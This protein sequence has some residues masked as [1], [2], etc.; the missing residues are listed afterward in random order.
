MLRILRRFVLPVIL[1]IAIGLRFWRIDT[2]PPGFHFDESFEGLEAWRILTDPG[3][4]PIFLTGNF[5]VAPFNAYANTL[6]FGLFQWWGSAVGPT[7]MRVT[8]ACFGVLGVFAMVGVAAEVRKLD[9]AK[10]PLSSTFPLFA[11]AALAVMRWHIH[12]SRMGI[13]PILVPLTWTVATWLLLRGWRTG[14]WISF[15][16]CGVALAAG[17]YTYQGAWVIPFIM[18]LSVLYLVFSDNWRLE[19]GDW[20][21]GA[22]RTISGTANLQS[23][24]SNLPT[25]RRTGLFLAATVALLL[26]APLAWFF[27]QNWALVFLRP[28]Q[29]AIVGATGSPADTSVW[30]NLWATAKMFGPLGNPGDLDPRRNLPGAPALNLWLAIPF[31][32]GVG[33]A[34]WRIRRPVYA[35]ILTGLV[36]LVVLGVF[37]EYA[38]HFHRILG[39]AA[40]VALLCAVGLDWLWQWQPVRRF[41][42]H[43]VSVLLLILGGATSAHEYFVR[44]AALPELFYAFDD[45]IWQVGQTVAALPGDQP[46]YLTPRAADHPTLAFAW[47][48]QGRPAPVTFDGRH[49]FPLAAQ[50]SPQPENYIVI[51]HEDFRTDLLLPEVFPAATIARKWLDH[52]GNVYARFYQRGSGELAQRPPQQSLAAQLGDGIELVGY[53]VQPAQLHAGDILYLQLHWQITAAPRAEWTVFTHVTQRDSAGNSQVIAGRDSVPGNGSLPTLRWQAGWRI[54]DEYQISLPAD[55]APGEYGLTVGLY[56]TTGERL[57]AAGVGIQ[58]GT[59]IIE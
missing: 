51:A 13:E 42:G 56:Q 31:Y 33:L 17:M 11:A 18:V 19:I 34:I 4:R 15:V 58:L 38:P 26:F 25:K 48:T 50:P 46:T 43:W 30:H 20:G 40:P 9:K 52:Q 47:Q 23:P 37:S 10:F 16:G 35:L 59:V 5:G 8:A 55:L 53:D 29:L 12:F 45:G 22:N 28:A 21:L 3:Y 57:P 32:L 36:G 54:L 6:M 14:H 27:W 24:I 2:L 39:A 41:S 1:L 44:W 7:P 49:I